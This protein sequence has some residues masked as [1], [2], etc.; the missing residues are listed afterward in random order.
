MQAVGAGTQRPDSVG[1]SAKLPDGRSRDERIAQAFDTSAFTQPANFR[2]G[3]LGRTVPDLRTDGVRN[4]DLS[5][6]KNWT[7]RERA[8][9][10]LRGEFFN[11]LNYA[12]LD[13]PNSSFNTAAFA[14]ITAQ[15]STP[16]QI[17]V[18][19]RLNF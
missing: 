3:N 18:S 11:S 5:I 14:V 9:L 2:F 13:R 1:R 19:L 16:R 10:Q 7:I 6:F 12:Q 15:A 17:Q 8:R 4:L